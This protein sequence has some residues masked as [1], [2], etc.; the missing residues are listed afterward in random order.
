MMLHPIDWT[1]IAVYLVGCVAAGVWMKRYV[2]GVEDFAVAGRA[3]NTNLGVA[4]LAATELGI[5]T[6]MYTAQFGF[7][8]GFVGAMPGVLTA[9]AMLLVGMTGFVITPL[10]DASVITIPELFEKRFGKLVR[11]LAGLVVVLGG[12]LNMGVFLR[13]GGEFLTHVT[14]LGN[15]E[16]IH[17]ALPW[18][19]GSATLDAGYLELTM[20]ALLA[21]VLV[22]TV[23][24]GMLSVLV[25]DY[26][27][28]L[29]MGL[30]IVVTSILVVTNTG[31][32]EL[33][34]RLWEAF[35]ATAGAA[36][37]ERNLVMT[38]PFNPFGEGG[39][40]VGWV[41]WQAIHALAVVTTWQT[42]ISRV[43]AAKNAATARS[44]Y[45]RA[46]FYWVGRWGL[47]GL[48]GAAAFVYFWT[49]P[50]A[51]GLLPMGLDSQTAMPA[52]LN[53][54]LPVG[55]LGL[56]IA[57][58]L[59][60]EMSTDSGYLLTW[61]TVIYNDLIMPCLGRH[62]PSARARLLIV[63]SMVVLIGL[64]LVFYGLWYKL[65]KTAVW[66]YLALTGDIYLA[67]IFALLVGALYWRGANA[68]GAV[69]AIVLGAAGPILF[70]VVNHLL[71][72]KRVPVSLV[73]AM[74]P[75]MNAKKG[76]I[77]PE[78]IGLAAFILAFA[79]M[80]L[81]SWAWRV[82]LER[83]APASEEEKR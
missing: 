4:S 24:G 82:L 62:Q 2:R 25:T 78:V 80:F 44:M 30:G 63:R 17:I 76:V 49:R 51:A 34:D 33:V 47:P 60:A 54:I 67:S 22:Y 55:V 28:F 5:V 32:T 20:T 52:F 79:G 68:V 18:G 64:F 69:A 6:V 73:A 42:T 71:Q 37:G 8:N 48:W 23:L 40:G 14:G 19:D 38:N 66:D 11:W 26:L 3:M 57:A 21:I 35:R 58:M 56:L 74:E 36:Q 46:A 70:V 59:A 13:L 31:W 16:G 81:G 45:R 15:T 43:L 39:I 72:E 7:Q 65:G 50:D 1:I 53:A 29:V 27:Q 77:L 12:V 10:R 61:A 9:A 83:F 75:I 41:V